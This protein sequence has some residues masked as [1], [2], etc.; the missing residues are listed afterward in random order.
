MDTR[1]TALSIYGKEVDIEFWSLE[2]S[3]YAIVISTFDKNITDKIIN[4]LEIN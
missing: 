3:I 1:G 2:D 4:T